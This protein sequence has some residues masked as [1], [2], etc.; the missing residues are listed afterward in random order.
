MNGAL[1]SRKWEGNCEIDWRT[2]LVVA[3]GMDDVP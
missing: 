2:V 1:D 3:R